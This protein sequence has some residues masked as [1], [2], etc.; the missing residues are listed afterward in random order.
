MIIFRCIRTASRA[1]FLIRNYSL[2]KPEGTY[3]Q[4][5]PL[6]TGNSNRLQSLVLF[7]LCALNTC[8]EVYSQIPNTFPGWD[9]GLLSACRTWE[10]AHG[11]C[12]LLARLRF[13]YISVSNWQK[14]NS[15]YEVGYK[16]PFPSLKK[17][18]REIQ[19]LNSLGSAVTL[20][21]LGKG[22]VKSCADLLVVCLPTQI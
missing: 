6:Y 5:A 20:S 19:Q 1:G 13:E 7:F 16:S 3:H 2:E 10:V 8:T 11:P 9:L 22:T 21:S 4:W 14:S 17:I 12:S 15:N 18:N